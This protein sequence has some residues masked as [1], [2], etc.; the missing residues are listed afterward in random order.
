MKQL[1]LIIFMM[2]VIGE[3]GYCQNPTY[4]LKATNITRTAPNEYTFEIRMQHTNSTV[5]FEYAG[6]Q[7]FFEFNSQI[8]NGGVFGFAYA[9]DS[10]DLPVKLRPRNPQV[11]NTGNQYW[12]LRMAV[13]T[14]QGAGN[15]YSNILTNSPGTKIAKMKLT[16]TADSFSLA[17]L[18]LTWRPLE[19]PNPNP[20]IFAYIN[21]VNTDI[22]N[23]QYHL[24]DSTITY[25]YNIGI[26]LAIEGLWTSKSHT[27]SDSIE[28]FLKNSTPPFQTVYSQRIK[29]DSMNLTAS[30]P[31]M[32]FSGTY[33]LVIKHKNTLET[34]SKTGGEALGNANYFYDFTTSASQAYGN[35]MVLKDGL[36]CI[37]SGNVNGD[38]VIDAEDLL[39]VD[40]AVFNYET[41]TSIANLNG[42]NIVDIEDMAICDNNARA[43]RVVERP[44]MLDDVRKERILVNP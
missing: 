41:G 20:K 40:N 11:F 34:W 33:Y 44:V 23:P 12:Q 26:R 32:F 17:P 28:V 13:N 18:T 36:Y 39:A 7:Y 5:Y 4:I 21:G 22:T 1:I 3:A 42:D 6:G 29:L 30:F 10:S 43:I 8:S 37:Y 16:T 27:A 19:G 15:G 9:L 31:L 38:D 24:V 35:N 14:F 25:L 2:A